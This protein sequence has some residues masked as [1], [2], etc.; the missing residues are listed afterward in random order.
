MWP[1]CFDDG[2]NCW[3]F[4]IILRVFSS[5]PIH[6]YRLIVCVCLCLDK[7]VCALRYSSHF[8]ET[9]RYR[10]ND[11]R[12][13]QPG[14]FSWRTL[15]CFESRRQGRYEVNQPLRAPHSSTHSGGLMA[16]SILDVLRGGVWWNVASF[17][18]FF[19]PETGLPSKS[20]G[21]VSL[22]RFI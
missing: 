1:H 8:V 15:A 3:H 22:I 12:E 16:G 11:S 19:F 6:I 14:S 2:V 9:G 20:F 13:L 7:C 18:F 21:T 4:K 10:F 5:H 17:T